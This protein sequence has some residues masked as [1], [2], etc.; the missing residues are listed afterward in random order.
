MIGLIAVPLFV[1]GVCC[2][3]LLR[4]GM[5]EGG[6]ESLNTPPEHLRLTWKNLVDQRIREDGLDPDG[7]PPNAAEWTDPY[8][9]DDD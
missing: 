9:V 5:P 2:V 8:A 7:P 4:A 6:P 3:M 1:I